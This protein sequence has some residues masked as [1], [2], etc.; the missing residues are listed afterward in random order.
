[1]LRQAGSSSY[2]MRAA[3]HR[4]PR[5]CVAVGGDGKN[6]L[7]VELDLVADTEEKRIAREHRAD[8]DMPGHVVAADHIAHPGAAR[9][10]SCEIQ[11]GD[12][13]TAQGCVDRPT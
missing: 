1:M 8:I 3:M 7:T 12:P 5:C 6:D 11:A 9:R 4:A 10:T 2:S 13:A